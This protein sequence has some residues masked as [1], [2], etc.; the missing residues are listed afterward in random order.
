LTPAQWAARVFSL[1]H[2]MITL[3]KRAIRRQNPGLN[4]FELKILYLQHF[5]GLDIAR[6]VR[7]YLEKKF[8]NGNQ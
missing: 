3:S 2:E 6:K 1:S 7:T 8:K 5:Y 4:E